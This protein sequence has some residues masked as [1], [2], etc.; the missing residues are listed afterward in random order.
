M[1]HSIDNW[2]T[3]SFILLIVDLTFPLLLVWFLGLCRIPEKATG[4]KSNELFHYL[5][6]TTHFGIK[7]CSKFR[8]LVGFTDSD[9][10]G[11]NDDWKV[12][13]WLCVSLQ[14]WTIGLVVQET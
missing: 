3:V 4:K 10:D 9:W 8:L 6:G 2:S 12:H 14:H 1:L 11:D 13:F 5:K 7:Y